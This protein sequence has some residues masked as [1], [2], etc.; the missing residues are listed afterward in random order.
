MNSYCN[1]IKYTEHYLVLLIMLLLF[2]PK[3]YATVNTSL[4]TTHH[5]FSIKSEAT[6]VIYPLSSAK[7][8]S[9]SVTNP[10]D[11]PIL[12]QTQ[13]KGEDKHSAAPFVVT[14]PLFRLDGGMRGQIRVIRTGGK[15]PQDRESLQLLCLT[16]VP[17]KGGDLWDN[18]SYEQKRNKD[19]KGINLDIRLSI[20]TCMKLFIRP[21]QLK[22]KPED[23]AGKLTWKYKGKILEVN[24]PTP[25]YMNF[26]SVYL[27]GKNI[28][29][30]SAD[31]KNYVAPY[32]KKSFSFSSGTD[33]SGREVAWEIINDYGGISKIFKAG[34]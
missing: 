3:T 28:D 34:I 12:V 6:R 4:H 20:S 1:Y 31:N 11:Y 13:V 27:G 22:N 30:F 26:H 14:P 29:L 7:G 15:F 9:L 17:P 10:Q 19:S 25:F 24:N 2:L 16:G 8:V 23:V 21:E 5:S 18:S 33:L 32:S